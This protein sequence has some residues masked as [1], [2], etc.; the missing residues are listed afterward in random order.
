MR[1]MLLLL[2]FT[3]PQS[4]TVRS[5]AHVTLDGYEACATIDEAKRAVRLAPLGSAMAPAN[6]AEMDMALLLAQIRASL[7]CGKLEA[8]RRVRVMDIEG[9]PA[10]VG[11][12]LVGDTVNGWAYVDAGAVVR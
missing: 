6:R 8:Q 4:F 11:V 3:L 12:R 1:T 9:E 2:L 10:I 5:E 7:R